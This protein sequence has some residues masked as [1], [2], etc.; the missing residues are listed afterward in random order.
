MGTALRR[1]M[2]RKEYVFVYIFTSSFLSLPLS[3][4]A[5]PFLLPFIF[6]IYSISFIQL[7]IVSYNLLTVSFFLTDTEYEHRD[8]VFLT[9][10]VLR[11][12]FLRWVLFIIA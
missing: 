11:V 10:E 5:I 2:E 7:F 4:T 8:A 6:L 1:L 3:L 12:R 9:L